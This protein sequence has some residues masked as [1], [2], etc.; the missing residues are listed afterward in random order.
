MPAV[1]YECDTKKEHESKV[2]ENR[3]PKEIFEPKRNGVTGYGDNYIKG[4]SHCVLSSDIIRV[5]TSTN[6]RCIGHL[7]LVGVFKSTNRNSVG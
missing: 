6:I 3:E 2:F 5:F 1:L 4:T 7:V